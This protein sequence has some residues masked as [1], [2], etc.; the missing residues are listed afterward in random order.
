MYAEVLG[1]GLA[2]HTADGLGE[3]EPAG[4][5]LGRHSILEEGDGEGEDYWGAV[6]EENLV[7]EIVL[8]KFTCWEG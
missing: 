4:E 5:G 3:G 1:F 7:L 8:V 2:V 6:G